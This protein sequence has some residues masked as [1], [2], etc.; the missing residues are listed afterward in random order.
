VKRLREQYKGIAPVD[1]L[2]ATALAYSATTGAA[3]SP[4]SFRFRTLMATMLSPQTKDQQTAQAYDNLVALVG[5]ETE[6]RASALAKK[7][8]AEIESSCQPVSF[9][10]TKARNIYAAAQRLQL[11]HGDDLPHDIET[12]LTFKGVGP[13]IAYVFCYTIV[14]P[15]FLVFDVLSLS[16]PSITAC[17]PSLTRY[18]V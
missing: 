17:L 2:G 16:Y 18:D 4:T 8:L 9:Y 13:K 10:K 11:E 1:S 5:D 14:L 7:T 15:S 12:I 3:V 6:F